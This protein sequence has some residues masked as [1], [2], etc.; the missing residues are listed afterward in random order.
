MEG[1]RRG[2]SIEMNDMA[3]TQG[4]GRVKQQQQR[5]KRKHYQTGVSDKI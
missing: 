5:A 4:G 2:G 1:T 3:T